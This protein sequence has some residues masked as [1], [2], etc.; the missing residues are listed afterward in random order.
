MSTILLTTEN[1]S[2]LGNPP[3]GE[4]YLAVDTDGMLKLKRQTDTITLGLTGSV[5][6]S[7]HNVTYTEFDAHISGSTLN[8]GD[9]YIITD[10]KTRHYIQY[11]DTVGDGSGG[12]EDIKI[13]TTEQLCVLATS[14][15]TYDNRVRSLSYPDDFIIWEHDVADRENDHAGGASSKGHILFRRSINGNERDYDFR[16]VVFRRWNDGSGNYNIIRKVDAPVPGDYIETLA[17]DENYHLNNKIGSSFTQS[18]SVYYMDN[19]VFG[20]PSYASYNTVTRAAGSTIES[21]TFSNNHIG[22]LSHTNFIGDISKDNK[23]RSIHGSTLSYLVN[24]DIGKIEYTSLGTSSNNNIS[25][26]S[27]SNISNMNNNSLEEISYQISTTINNN[28]GGEINNNT[29]DNIS[30]NTFIEISGNTASSIIINN[31]ERI[32]SNSNGAT[33]SYNKVSSLMNNTNDGIISE[34]EGTRIGNNTG[35]GSIT[36]NTSKEILSNTLSGD[37]NYNIS[38]LIATNSLASIFGNKV[39]EI[40]LN[41]NGTVSN[42]T[43][44]MI[45][46]NSISLIDSNIVDIIT[47]N[48]TASNIYQNISKEISYNSG[49]IMNNNVQ[50]ITFNSSIVD[51]NIGLTVSLN[52]VTEI[53]K[54]TSDNIL[55]NLSSVTSSIIENGVKDIS[56]NTSVGTISSNW[57][58]KISSNTVPNISDNNVHEIS[59]N[60][61]S[62]ITNNTGQLIR[63]N[64]DIVSNGGVIDLNTVNTIQ[65]NT[66]FSEIK[67]NDGNLISSNLWSGDLYTNATATFSFLGAT[68]AIGDQAIINLA[69]NTFSV[70]SNTTSSTGFI[71]G[72][73]ATFPQSGFTGTYSGLDFIVTAPTSIISYEG[74]P[75][76]IDITGTYSLI[77][78]TPAYS[79]SG[80]N[81]L[82]LDPTGFLTAS[83]VH[84]LVYI[85][86][87]GTPDTFAWY[88]DQGNTG[89]GS[90][91]TAPPLPLSY[92]TEITFGNTTGHSPSDNWDFTIQGSQSQ[93]GVSYTSTFTGETRNVL[94]KIKYNNVTRINSN[95]FNLIEN[96]TANEISGNTS[97]GS[98][99]S[100]NTTGNIINGTTS[101]SVKDISKGNDILSV[102]NLGVTIVPST[103]SNFNGNLVFDE[104]GRVTVDNYVNLTVSSDYVIPVS[105]TL[106]EYYGVTGSVGPITITL[107]DTTN[108]NN[109]K[110]V[111]I[112]DKSGNAAAQNI[113]IN[114]WTASLIDNASSTTISSNYGSVTLI[115]DD[116]N[117]WSI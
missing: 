95:S 24:N 115:I 105:Y 74:D 37:I 59:S 66:N 48:A 65:N 20:T 83:P 43:G 54:N 113:T 31:S 40:S 57:G 109:N 111:I 106:Q 46:S 71:D 82:I 110:R 104:N 117:W 17:H 21:L 112:K 99:L 107:P 26:I 2:A 69:G 47:Q 87:I 114:S 78:E 23:I 39:E 5:Y 19:L 18:T 28:K 11:T 67:Y 41:S 9:I 15:N 38:K 72:I 60:T 32:T 8:T 70:I 103:S 7:T 4:Y 77:S 64:N 35:T 1:V 76:S 33:I 51:G 53:R 62:T 27:W 98:Y 25:Q 68:V 75:F 102:D 81:D 55:A 91:R 73:Y 90:V 50:I 42:N 84:Y 80:L 30:D 96:N 14:P 92:G 34:N 36:K 116:G 94:S 45:K 10:Y 79:G 61:Q 89:T 108:L 3:V 100:N 93:L 52:T 13:G 85:D 56:L 88:D 58:N 12:S 44:E 97:S 22:E 101:M 16:Q 6:L 49:D 63:L 29:V 86:S